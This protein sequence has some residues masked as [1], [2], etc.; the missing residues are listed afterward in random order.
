MNLDEFRKAFDYF[1]NETIDSLKD[2]YYSEERQPD[3][4]AMANVMKAIN[5]EV[6]NETDLANILFKAYIDG[7]KKTP[8]LHT[9]KY[10]E[11]VYPSGATYRLAIYDN[12]L[13][14]EVGDE[15]LVTY[16]NEGMKQ[17]K[18]FWLKVTDKVEDKIVGEIGELEVRF[19][20]D[21]IKDKR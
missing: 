16:L 3:D 18:D 19:M 12:D 21:N 10:R 17:P 4:L 5:F 8:G 13:E 6:Q 1:S 20:E 15:I 11:Y 9:L 2:T 7:L 14:A